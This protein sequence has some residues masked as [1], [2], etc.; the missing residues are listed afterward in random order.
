MKRRIFLTPWISN[1]FG[2]PCKVFLF[3]ILFLIL[4]WKPTKN[5][6][7]TARP[8]GSKY[9]QNTPNDVIL[10]LIGQWRHRST[11]KHFKVRFL[12]L[13]SFCCNFV[14]FLVRRNLRRKLFIP[15]MP[16]TLVCAYVSKVCVWGARKMEDCLYVCVCEWLDTLKCVCVFVGVCVCETMC[17]WKPW[18]V[19]VCVCVCVCAKVGVLYEWLCVNVWVCKCVCVCVRGWGAGTFK[20]VKEREREVFFS[21][22]IF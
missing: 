18:C 10:E 8:I 3:I 1:P 20:W 6:I 11:R 21:V 16:F 4:N 14:T 13:K 22:S 9:Y 2:M 12:F 5:K 17:A 7:E 15:L 19:C